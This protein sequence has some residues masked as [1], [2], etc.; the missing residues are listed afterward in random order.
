MSSEAGGHYGWVY[1]PCWNKAN[2]ICQAKQTTHQAK[3]DVISKPGLV[4][5]LDNL[6]YEKPRND[7]DEQFSEHLISFP[8]K[9]VYQTELDKPARFHGTPGSFF[10]LENSFGGSL[11]FKYGM[12]ISVWINII[13]VEEET[14][15]VIV[16][17]S[18]SEADNSLRLYL[19]KIGGKISAVAETC[20]LDCSEVSIHE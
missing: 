7:N 15:A 3:K 1:L 20:N 10:E 17:F 18:D 5:P 11:H 14:K 6:T 19:K 9:P 4:M 12:T 2:F 8:H 13:A 16:D